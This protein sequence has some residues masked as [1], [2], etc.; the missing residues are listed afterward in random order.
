MSA[1]RAGTDSNNAAPSA[2]E[3]RGCFMAFSFLCAPEYFGRACGI[4]GDARGCAAEQ[5][6]SCWMGLIR[7]C[8]CAPSSERD[9]ILGHVASWGDRKPPWLNYSQTAVNC[10]RVR[11]ANAAAVRK[12]HALHRVRVMEWRAFQSHWPHSRSIDRYARALG[13]PAWS[14][15]DHQHDAR[16]QQQR[17]H[18]LAE[19]G[20]V[21]PA[22]QFEAEPGA[23]EQRR[24]A[25]QEQ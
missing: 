17:Q 10:Q 9:A 20:L 5:P 3:G 21:E 15:L 11:A 14:C 6:K 8:A 7:T 18:D 25:N 13:C 24:Q 12:L 19:R 4:S 16:Q 2:S 1:A 22:V 23:G